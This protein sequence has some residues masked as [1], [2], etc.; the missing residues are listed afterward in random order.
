MNL[1]EPRQSLIAEERE[2]RAGFRQGQERCLPAGLCAGEDPHRKLQLVGRLEREK[3]GT[4][5]LSL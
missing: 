4:F 5:L 1:E 2:E 3:G